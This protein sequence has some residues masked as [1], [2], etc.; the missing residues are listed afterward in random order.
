MSNLTSPRTCY[1]Q[2]GEDILAHHILA[3]L[4]IRNGYAGGYVDVGCGHPVEYNNTYLFYL[5]G[6]RG[7]HVDPDPTFELFYRQAR[8]EDTFLHAAIG[9]ENRPIRY[10][11]FSPYYYSTCDEERAE[12]LMRD[13]SVCFVGEEEVRSRRLADVLDEYV[14]T[15]HDFSLD[16][17]TVDVEGFEIEVLQSNDWDRFRPKVLILE[18]LG[19]QAADGL[20]RT[21]AYRFVREIGFSL[22]A[23]T[24]NSFV[25]ADCRLNQFNKY[26]DLPLGP[27]ICNG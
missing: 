10:Y 17:M 7:L 25:F 6:W 14:G 19:L 26:P 20:L 2:Y 16:L 27:L 12:L 11:R 3:A 1:S 21:S 22:K 13:P 24:Q 4:D 8:S 15:H 18:I 23:M 5:D 9:T